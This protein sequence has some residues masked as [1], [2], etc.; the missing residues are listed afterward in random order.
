MIFKT[1]AP[2]YNYHLIADTSGWG[3]FLGEIVFEFSKIL[4]PTFIRKTSCLMKKCKIKFIVL[5]TK[6]NKY[7]NEFWKEIIKIRQ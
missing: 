3:N 2:K 4:V 5:Q 1:R 7:W 6:C